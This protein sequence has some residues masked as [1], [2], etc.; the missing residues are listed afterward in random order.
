MQLKEMH[1]QQGLCAHKVCCPPTHSLMHYTPAFAHWLCGNENV[2]ISIINQCMLMTLC[3]S[4]VSLHFTLLHYQ[5][6]Y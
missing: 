5:Q 6:G 3:F 4:S 1:S 2:H